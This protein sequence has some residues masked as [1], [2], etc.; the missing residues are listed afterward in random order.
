MTNLDR[1]IV[2]LEQV[3]IKKYGRN[4]LVAEKTGYATGMVAK[5]LSGHVALT[6]R[7]IQAVC[8]AF[9]I[10]REWI[11]EG[12]EPVKNPG[13]DVSATG[14]Q[15]GEGNVLSESEE[16]AQPGSLEA[17]VQ[18]L[19]GSEMDRLPTNGEKFDLAADLR[20][21]LKKRRGQ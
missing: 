19:V 7:F 1:L 3:G 5:V 18:E 14:R 16:K 17:L 20:D 15:S 21:F 8:S 4:V 9:A 11:Y 6:D 10:R 12:E 2:G 13:L